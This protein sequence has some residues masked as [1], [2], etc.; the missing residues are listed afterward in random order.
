MQRKSNK[1]VRQVTYGMISAVVGHV[2]CTATAEGVIQTL[3]RL[4]ERAA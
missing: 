4:G 3:E 2:A 1:I